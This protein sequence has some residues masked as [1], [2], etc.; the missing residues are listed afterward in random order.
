MTMTREPLQHNQ[1]VRFLP[2]YC[3]GTRKNGEP[4]GQAL[5]KGDLREVDDVQKA[6]VQDK[7]PRC[8]RV[9]YFG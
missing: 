8:G 7:C 3:P 5:F 9:A 6:V 4:C 2:V 1:V